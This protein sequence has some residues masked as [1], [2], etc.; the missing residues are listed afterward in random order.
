MSLLRRRSTISLAAV[1]AAVL[2]VPASAALA[3]DDSVVRITDTLE[4]AQLEVAAG[5]TVTWRN[6]D[7]E[8]HRV[9]SREGSQELD[10]G[11]LEPGESFTFTFSQA[12]TYPYL[13]ERDDDDS[14]YFGTIVVQGT[15]GTPLEGDH[16]AASAQVSM[17]DE[18]FIP[19]AVSIVTGGT[20]TWS[21]D[22]GD[23]QHTVTSDDG[24][25]GSDVLEGGATFSHTFDE[26]GTYPY[27]CLIHPEM[28]GTVTVAGAADAVAPSVVPAASPS[29]P[30]AS[31][32]SGAQSSSPGAAESAST[33]PSALASPSASASTSASA[34][35]SPSASG[36]VAQSP[37][38]M[39]GRAFQ[40]GTV[41]VAAGQTVDW[42]NDDGEAHTVSAL[43]GSFNSGIMN[44]GDAFSETFETPGTFDYICAIHPTMTGTVI[45]T[46]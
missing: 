19:S 41:E 6:E 14:D 37:V 2:L 32:A 4:P 15:G 24:A 1:L 35:A 46:E 38:T 23:D 11:N 17:F 25:F 36:A 3:Q 21:N 44:S 33:S 10:S 13:D 42:L 29:A 12:G 9:R 22:D 43:D 20:V 34:S 40:P 27:T 26:A 30:A 5:S 45:V 8:R 7:D 16:P 31:S 18:A 28:R 39:L